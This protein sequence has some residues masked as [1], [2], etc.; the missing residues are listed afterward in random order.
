MSTQRTISMHV[1]IKKLFPS[2]MFITFA[3]IWLAACM[4]IVSPTVVA[5]VTPVSTPQEVP[6]RALTATSV[7]TPQEV[8]T[9]ALTATSVAAATRFTC[10]DSAAFISDVTIPDN[11]VIAAN[12]AFAKKWRLKN[13]GTCTWDSNYLVA[14][15]SG[16]TMSQQ[17][18]YWIVQK[19]QTVAPGQTVD[20]SVG[21]TSPVE[22]GTYTS[23][24]GMKKADDEFMPIQGGAKGNSF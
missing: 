7:P 20:I 10:T 9:R 15:I 19:G 21:M 22:N 17:P 1:L 2:I 24:W 8:P 6:T 5:T 3:T 13:T 23:Y 14:Y 12:T 11:T 18:G 4:P 16:A